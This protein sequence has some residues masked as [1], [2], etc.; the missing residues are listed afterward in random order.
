MKKTI[1][2]FL[3]VFLLIGSSLHG[4]GFGSYTL[5]KTEKSWKF[6]EQICKRVEKNKL[7]YIASYHGDS[8]DYCNV[9]CV[10]AV[11][12]GETNCYYRIKLDEDANN[13]ILCTP[14]QAFYVTNE[15]KWIFA[16][17]L[18]KGDKLL[19]Q[20]NNLIE[21]V[22]IEFIEE[23]LNVYSLEVSDTHN[24]FVSY[25]SV[26]VH[27]IIFPTAI[28][29]ISGSFGTGAAAGSFFGPI[30]L[31]G[32]IIIGGIIGILANHVVGSK[33][34]AHQY[35][36]EYDKNKINTSFKD[37]GQGG[38]NQNIEGSEQY[39]NGPNFPEDP[40][41]EN[42]RKNSSLYKDATHS[43]SRYPNTKTN[44]TRQNFENNL[45]KNGW[46]KQ[47]SKDGRATIY[48]KD[49][50]KYII[51]NNAKSTGG[52]TADYYECEDS[53]ITLKIRLSGE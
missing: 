20:Y 45:Q 14:S 23:P 31:C 13:D 19:A 38:Q 21:I 43:K 37:D 52:P 39:I 44:I 50:A 6:I 49:G 27:N 28:F 7:E 32:G 1:L 4:H 15:N 33:S 5:V 25:Y 48:S 35:Q 22:D 46:K 47:L 8:Q 9:K 34:K 2:E 26:L 41:E 36:V 29:G 16:C 51:R 18:K 30:T 53:S 12:E 10:K 17:E 24:F 40:D 11:G 3:F 42:N